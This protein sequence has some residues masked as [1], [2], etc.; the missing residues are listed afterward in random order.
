MP[1]T[2]TKQM[3]SMCTVTHIVAF[4]K[5]C[6]RWVCIISIVYVVVTLQS[7]VI[8][9]T[10]TSATRAIERQAS[11]L[12]QSTALEALVSAA[13]QLMQGTGPASAIS[14]LM[15]A[16]LGVNPGRRALVG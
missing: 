5:L 2:T 13:P 12:L 8:Q 6:G 11:S 10:L 7:S 9:G 4:S 14:M 3:D 15:L 16:P 1:D